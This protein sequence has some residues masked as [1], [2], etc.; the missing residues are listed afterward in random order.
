MFPFP[1]RRGVEAS[2]LSLLLVVLL[3]N[4]WAANVCSADDA[5]ELPVINIGTVFDGPPPDGEGLV[6][7][8]LEG[9]VELI[10]QETT[11]LTRREFDV[12]FPEEKQISGNW[13]LEQIRSAIQRQLAD[14][15]VNLVL[16]MGIFSTNDV[17]RRGDLPKPVVAPFAIDIDAQSLPF[18]TDRQG[19]VITGVKNLNYITTPGSILR[20]LRKFREIVPFSRIHVLTDA[21]VP[22]AIPEIPEAV[23]AGGRQLGVEIFPPVPVID[24]ADDTLALL[25]PDVEAV[26]ITPLHRMPSDEFDRLVAGLIERRLPSFTLI[27]REEVERGVMAGVRPETDFPRLARRI[28][29]NIQRILMGEDAGSL[30]VRL[31]LQEKLVINLE[32]A[33]A[34]GVFP[35]I[36]V[37]MEAELIKGKVGEIEQT[38][39]LSEA[40]REAVEANLSL[41]VTDRRVAAGAEEIRRARS[42]LKPQIVASALGLEIDEDRAEASF[43]SQAERT[44]SGALSVSQIIYSDGAR[45]NVEI[46]TRLQ[47][48]LEREWES[49]RLEVALD[50]A[51]AFLNTL[52]AETLENVERENLRLTETNLKLARRREQIGFSG[53]ADVYRW[54]SELATARS[55]LIKAHSRV[56]AAYILL[57]RVLHRPL[58]D[59]FE[60]E[61][62]KLEDPELVTGFG[63]LNPYVDNAAN[64]TLFKEFMVREGIANSPELESI[65]SAIAAQQRVLKT[66]RRSYWSPD[67]AVVGDFERKIS[68]RGAGSEGTIPPGP[69][70]PADR[71]DWSLAVQATLPLFTGGFR[72][73]Q[74]R[75]AGEQLSELRLEREAL[76]ESVDLRVRAAMYDLTATFPSIE[77]AQEAGEAALKNLDLVTDSYSRGVLSIIDLLDA[78]N[79]ALVAQEFAANAEYDF[80]IDLMELQRATNGFDFFRSEAE[81]E[82]WFHRLET[83]FAENA[84]RIRWPKR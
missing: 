21:L 56:H 27:G 26:Y 38:L 80:L 40:V 60:A 54:E 33:T 61:P 36:R 76:L 81:R 50:A 75:Q 65:D 84:D 78:Q 49:E 42:F 11:S 25:P 57:N 6:P 41:R 77:L 34:V 18:D 46:S 35:R 28:A 13:K 53:P 30:P 22:R 82:S 17:C 16:T 24:S 12:R 63:R 31:E 32:T 69:F 14:T 47:Y 70:G 44:V 9:L 3:T 19:R 8:R 73:A 23:I 59:L 64:F 58:E 43:G 67:V 79:A 45:S 51:T 39:T 5:P 20:D 37:A 66:A 74:A 7:E 55:N 62:P 15:E 52:R 4:V 48:S 29:L 72:K 10:R 68:K 2:R 83:F 71:E 1:V